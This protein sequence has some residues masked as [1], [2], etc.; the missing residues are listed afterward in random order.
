YWM[1]MRDVPIV[2]GIVPRRIVRYVPFVIGL[3][4]LLGLATLFTRETRLIGLYIVLTALGLCLT[5]WPEQWPRYWAPAMPYVVLALARG[6][7]RLATWSQ[8]LPK[9]VRRSVHAGRVA[10]V[11]GI[12]VVQ[13]V[14]I[15]RI[16]S[17]VRFPAVL[18]ERDGHVVAQ[19]LF[20]YGPPYQALD[21]GLDWLGRRARPDDV[22]AASMPQWAYLRTGLKTVMPPFVIDPVDAQALLDS[23]PVRFVVVDG[24]DVNFTREYTL[25]LLESSPDRW[26]LVYSN[27]SEKLQIYERRAEPTI[28]DSALS[29]SRAGDRRSPAAPERP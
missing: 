17:E 22:V 25:P 29:P 9:G 2:G 24:T 28:R 18:R 13:V 12:L 15:I 8:R 20:F 7:M 3:I 4:V 27:P 5:P 19:H 6:L 14:S 10:L 23:V 1:R 21:A 26:M 16:Y 11:A